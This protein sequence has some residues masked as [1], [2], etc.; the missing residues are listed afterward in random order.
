VVTT[1]T[2]EVDNAV[3]AAHNNFIVTAD[4]KV[5]AKNV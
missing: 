4:G 2:T 3:I 1:Q 5:Y